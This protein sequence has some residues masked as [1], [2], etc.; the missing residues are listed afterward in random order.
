MRLRNLRRPGARLAACCLGLWLSLWLGVAWGAPALKVQI[1]GVKDELLE[2]VRQLLSIEQQKALQTLTPA[3]IR[4]LH[5]RAESEIKRALEPY[6]YYRARVRAELTQTAEGWLARY[7]ITP[8]PQIPI[9]TLQVQ[10]QGE[11]GNDPAF[12]QLVRE[13]PIREGEPLRH[14]HYEQAKNELRNLAAERGY[15]DAELKDHRVEVDLESYTARVHIRLESGKRYQFGAVQFEHTVV[16]ED[17]LRDYLPFQEGDPYLASKLLE[18]QRSLIDSDYFERVEVDPQPEQSE[19]LRV[20]VQ[21]KLT[22]QP[23]SRYS[24]G[25]G[26]GTD[27]GARGSVGLERRYVNRDGHRFRSELRVSQ[28]RTEVDARYDVP[29]R[30][31]RTDRLFARARFADEELDT[32]S[33]KSFEL[34]VGL[35]QTLGLWRQ[36]FSLTYLD[37]DFT[38]GTQDGHATLLMPGASWTRLKRDNSLFT[39][40]GSRV[41]IELRG[42]YEGL[43]SDTSFVQ[44]RTHAK[45]I[46]SIGDDRILVRGEAGS[47][48]VDDFSSLPPSV[49]F[50]AGGDYSVR[51]FAYQSLGPEDAAGNVIGGRHLLVGSVEYEHRLKEKWAAAIFYDA[52]NAIN[53]FGDE[54]EHSVGVGLRWRSPV[55]WVRV[56][57][58]KP[59]SEPDEGL[60]LH[61][62]IGPDL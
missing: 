62:T 55:G 46:R 45:W 51:G 1:E 22:A 44:V 7:R 5:E 9:K 14:Q 59:L 48:W 12:A 19:G 31:P 56:D 3:R 33:S 11:A 41:G 36:V 16:N 37:S 21:V 42:A 29:V 32:S 8:G 15:F 61:L 4:R 47:T 28:I 54:L 53:N 23:R 49:R 6:G 58:A 57:L 20:P 34:G 2:N 60:R 35:E 30:D 26:Y 40:H 13:L 38:I 39:R 43:V 25:V 18:L 27:T 10:L 17:L 50:F 24:V 52:G